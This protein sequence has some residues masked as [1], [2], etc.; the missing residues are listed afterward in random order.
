MW[1]KVHC[2]HIW[3]IFHQTARAAIISTATSTEIT[4]KDYQ[5]GGTFQAIIGNWVSCTFLLK[6]L[7]LSVISNYHGKC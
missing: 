6:L 5:R 7:L 2:R 3:Q 1:K 4:T